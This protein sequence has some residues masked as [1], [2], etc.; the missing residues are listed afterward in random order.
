MHDDGDDLVVGLAAGERRRQR[1]RDR[2]GLQEKPAAAR[3]PLLIAIAA[4]TSSSR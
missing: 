3:L 1:R 2:L 4:V